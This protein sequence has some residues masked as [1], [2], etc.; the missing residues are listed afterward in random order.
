MSDLIRS[1]NTDA[2]SIYDREK[3][4]SGT[5]SIQIDDQD[6]FDYIVEFQAAK[7]LPATS[8]RKNSIEISR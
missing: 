4:S 2:A 7:V 3:D 8:R 1:K 6:R 5:A